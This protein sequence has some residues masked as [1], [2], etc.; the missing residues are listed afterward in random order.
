MRDEK[1]PGTIDMPL[2]RKRGR[3]PRN[4]KAMSAAERMRIYRKANARQVEQFSYHRL[5]DYS[6][7]V[8]LD[9]LRE[10]IALP[11]PEGVRV[12]LKELGRRH[13]NM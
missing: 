4:G 12:I 6:D 2:A 8:L 5:A 7:V 9:A 1:D 13:A 11:Y 3:P 10:D